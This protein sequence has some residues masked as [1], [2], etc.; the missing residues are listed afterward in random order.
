MK[1]T[2]KETVRHIIEYARS[3]AI[4]A[5]CMCHYECGSLLRFA[6][7]AVSLNTHETR[8]TMTITAY[9]GN[10]CGT[11]EITSRI[12][13]YVAFE[14]AV[15]YAADIAQHATPTQYNRTFITLPEQP[16]DDSL[17]SESLAHTSSDDLL[18]YVH[19]AI[20]GIDSDALSLSGII[21]AGGVMQAIGNTLS[22]VILFHAVSDANS[23]LVFQNKADRREIAAGESAICSSD[24]QPE[25]LQKKLKDIADLYL[26]PTPIE[27]STGEYTVVLGADAVAELI[28]MMCYIGFDGGMC[29]R[30]RTF[31]KEEHRGSRVFDSRLSIIDDPAVNDT[32]PYAFDL[33]GIS[34]TR[35]PLVENGVFTQ[36]VWDR[37]SADEFNEKET[38]HTVPAMSVI[39]EPGE[40][41]CADLPALMNMT[42]ENDV[43]YLPHLHYMNIVNPTQ[44]IVTCSSRFG[45]LLLRK[46]GTIDVPYNV[47][48]T[49][50]FFTLFKN[51]CWL[52]AE[53]SVVNTSDSYGARNPTAIVVPSFTQVSGVHITHA[54]TTF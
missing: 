13:D 27:I 5:E 41:L 36:F 29:K 40:T 44:G 34:R 7:S 25:K 39:V 6:Q 10:A 14:K 19:S 54:N 51:I 33:N 31:L 4:K 53:L 18:A 32:Y 8:V 16:D 37:D 17:Y 22:D 12:D 24:M 28:S 43:L 30:Q 23:S 3:H 20:E 1:N 26:A 9:N 50:N 47:R 2:L 42:R 21:T 15:L 46:D 48:M 52:S 35:F 11:A 45:A 38:G 49:E